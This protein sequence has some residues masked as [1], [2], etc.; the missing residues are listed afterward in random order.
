MGEGCRPTRR[1]EGRR[2]KCRGQIGPLGSQ[3]EEC[4]TVTP[5]VR[6]TR[7][8]MMRHCAPPRTGG[9]SDEPEVGRGPRRAAWALEVVVVSRAAVLGAGSADS[10]HPD[11]PDRR[12]A[13]L[14]SIGRRLELVGMLYAV[15]DVASSSQN[16]QVDDMRGDQAGS[17]PSVH[18]AGSKAEH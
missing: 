16:R 4:P 2:D 6:P 14:S 9:R 5:P 7:R 8:R 3:R 1:A 10:G 13:R 18:S 17:R 15:H 11:D 12:L